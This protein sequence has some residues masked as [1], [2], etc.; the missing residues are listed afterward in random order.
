F[1]L[2]STQGTLQA[3]NSPLDVAIT[4]NGFFAVND[5]G[6][7]LGNN[8]YTRAGSFHQDVQGRLVN[9]AGMFLEGWQLTQSGTISNVNQ[10][11]VV[12]VGTTNGVA[13]GTQH[14]TV[15]A[16]VDSSQ[17]I[18]TSASDTSTTT[19]VTLS[20][21][22]LGLGTGVGGAGLTTA[23]PDDLTLTLNGSTYTLDYAAASGAITGSGTAFAGT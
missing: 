16:N 10:L 2:I 18:F 23:T 17:A 1:A 8:L 19:H 6:N 3:S 20:T 7:G 14:V 9:S 15:G 5:Q 11:Q 12:S 13:V 4:G 22:D 21:N